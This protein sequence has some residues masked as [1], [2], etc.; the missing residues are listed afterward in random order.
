[1]W[2]G[3]IKIG[4]CF[5]VLLHLNVIANAKRIVISSQND[6][7]NLGPTIGKELDNNGSVDIVLNKGVYYYRNNHL[8]FNG[9]NNTSAKIRIEGKNA[10]LVP[11]KTAGEEITPYSAVLNNLQDENFWSSMYASSEKIVIINSNN[12][13]CR[14]KRSENND[15][16]ENDYILITK[17]FTSG[18]FKIDRFDDDYLYFTAIDTRF[19]DQYGEYDVNFDYV[20][21]KSFPRYKLFLNR[22]SSLDRYIC[23]DATFLNLKNCS[24]GSL[25]LKGLSFIGGSGNGAVVLM[26]GMNAAS[27]NVARCKFMALHNKALDIKGLSN[28]SIDKCE[29]ENCCSNVISADEKSSNLAIT[30][31]RWNKCGLLL[32][33]PSC[34]IMPSQGYFIK[35]NLF[36]DFYGRALTLGVY[37]SKGEAAHSYGE[38][39][40]NEFYFTTTFFEIGEKELLKDNG[41]IYV[42]TIND[43]LII[44]NNFI[45]D[46][47]GAGDN[48][49]IFMDDGARNVKVLGNVIVRVPK[50][51]SISSRRVKTVERI[52]GLA[53]VG[54]V[55]QENIF[56]GTVRFEGNEVE[57]NECVYGPNF[58]L[59]ED[60]D[61]S[62]QKMLSNVSS[63]EDIVLEY[64]GLK[65]GKIGISG[66]AKKELRKCREWNG[67]KK[68]VTT[69]NRR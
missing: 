33:N 34:I 16:G 51:H 9:I 67:I 56:E 28:I 49:G 64:T 2:H 48:R 17:W 29:F 24:L 57:N 23:E 43:N 52:A 4:I 45:H 1:M 60:N 59:L 14:I 15:V 18:I 11:V 19:R 37:Y 26:D 25:T 21:D 55:I 47:V 50:G 54:N 63:E 68:Y 27:V 8:L 62:P 44:R 31:C 65:L 12:K 6:F 53:N 40:G 10:I 58:F 61:A 66:N 30:N 39:V 7:D 5:I 22:G 42:N 41:A 46:F 3:C 38:V 69:V 35:N 13:L 20:Y 36:I 32:N